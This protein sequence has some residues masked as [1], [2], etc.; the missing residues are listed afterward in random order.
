MGDA[1]GGAP[2]RDA[3]GAAARPSPRRG[4]KVGEAP[5]DDRRHCLSAADR[6]GM[7]CS[8][9]ERSASRNN[10]AIRFWARDEA[11]DAAKL[12]RGEEAMLD[13]GEITALRVHPGIGVA[14]VGNAEGPDDFFFGSETSGETPSPGGGFRA[15]DGRL[16]RQAA[17]FRLYATLKCGDVVEI[18]ADDAEIEWRVE[19]G[20]LKAGWYRFV[21]AMDLP[22]N[23]AVSVERRNPQVGRDDVDYGHLR[24]LDLDIT[25]SQRR[26]SGR[27]A[28]GAD[29]RFDDGA[30]FG[31]RVYLGELRT[32]GLGRLLVLGGRGASE[33]KEPDAAPT[34][35]ANNDGWH[36]DVSD[37]P[38]RARVTIA[39]QTIEADP[40]YVVVAPPNYGPGLFGV[41]TMDD[42]VRQ[43]FVDAGFLSPAPRPSFTKDIWPIFDRLSQSQWVN[44]G[45]FMIHGAGSALDAR[46]PAVVAK[47]ADD[48]AD[49][50]FRDAVFRLF[51]NPSE[52][53]VRPAALPPYFGDGVDYQTPSEVAVRDDGLAL[54]SLTPTLYRHLEQ[55][56]AGDFDSD[57]TGFPTP[58]ELADL[59]PR[60][61]PEALDRA[62]MYELLGG[63]FH[64]GIELTWIMRAPQ[65]W[66]GCYRLNLLPEGVRARQDYGPELTP[67]TCMSR[68]GPLAAVGPGALTRWLGVPWQTDE[69]SCGSGGDYT[70]TY[71]LSVPSFWGPRVPNDVLPLAAFERLSE[72]DLE[73]QRRWKHFSSRRSWYR[74]I[75]RN[76]RTRPHAMVSEW[77]R[78]GVVEPRDLTASDGLPARVHVE[79]PTARD[80]PEQD[81]TFALSA[82]ADRLDRRDRSLM[83]ASLDG[84]SELDKRPFEQPRIRY[85]RDQA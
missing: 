66:K 76:G 83:T 39:G 71:Y 46:S 28:S 60:E 53:A 33:P 9:E 34:T 73:P 74:L 78:Q 11:L 42:V 65:L 15:A 36:D 41:L 77:W 17:R 26:I 25:P 38:V 55:W 64:P 23:L 62:A 72:P 5:H 81:P 30:F 8:L 6:H 14:R 20:N 40:G 18:T 21:A 7:I 56:A 48:G 63:P 43:A 16:K 27:D 10:Q 2:L 3:A 24:R 67:E 44:H 79:M 84:G 49:D 29:H 31:K 13:P 12:L 4:E 50:G 75:K 54:L 61:R 68:G 58:A 1:P 80:G 51:R 69:A 45:A 59:D 52:A 70:P 47:L 35:F 22:R 57:W 32:D 37:G 85:R 82:L 19:L